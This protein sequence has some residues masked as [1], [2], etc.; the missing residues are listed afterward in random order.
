MI[1]IS[2]KVQT[3]NKKKLALVKKFLLED[4][5]LHIREAVA[6]KYK[7]RFFDVRLDVQ[8][9]TYEEAR[10]CDNMPHVLIQVQ[11]CVPKDMAPSEKDVEDRI[12]QLNAQSHQIDFR[13]QS[14]D[15]VP[16]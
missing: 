6:Q 1:I 11:H 15:R 2:C 16:A 5:T 3:W 10:F 12:R 14:I 9:K 7:T 4:G 8:I 13:V